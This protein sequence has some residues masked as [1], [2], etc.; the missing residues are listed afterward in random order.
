[1]PK[2]FSPCS[3]STIAANSSSVPI[4]QPQ[5][6]VIPLSLFRNIVV[7][8]C[9]EPIL[10][11]Q[12]ILALSHTLASPHTSALPYT[13]ALPYTSALPHTLASPYTSALPY[14]LASPYTSALPY[15][16]ALPYTHALPIFE[17]FCFVSTNPPKSPIFTSANA[18]R[19]RMRYTFI[20]CNQPSLKV[21]ISLNSSVN[22]YFSFTARLLPLCRILSHTPFSERTS[23]TSRKARAAPASAS[24]R[25][26]ESSSSQVHSL[27]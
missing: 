9:L 26:P 17:R 11:H 1:M 8:A 16:L 27:P 21:S 12:K 22:S 4:K 18:L 14:T 25:Q 20:F 7:V 2:I 24:F 6:T 23:R 5:V 10:E 19:A 13:L 15:T 3:F